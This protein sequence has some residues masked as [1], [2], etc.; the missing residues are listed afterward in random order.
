MRTKK[1]KTVREVAAAAIKRGKTNAEV[2]VLVKKA[3]PYSAIS[4]ATVNWQ[5]NEMR[6]TLS[7]IPNDREARRKRG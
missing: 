1:A 6:K 4:T 5:R 3:H 2:L 7:M